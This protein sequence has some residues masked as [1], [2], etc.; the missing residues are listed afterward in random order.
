MFARLYFKDPNSAGDADRQSTDYRVPSRNA[1]TTTPKRNIRRRSLS[2]SL[3]HLP[4]L[5]VLSSRLPLTLVFLPC[6]RLSLPHSAKQKSC[7]RESDVE[8][9]EEEEGALARIYETLRIHSTCR[10]KGKGKGS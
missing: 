3:S 8:E 6:R 10:R 4:P 2:L 7:K 9:E 5:R 1:K